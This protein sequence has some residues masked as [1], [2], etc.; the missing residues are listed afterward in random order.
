MIDALARPTSRSGFYFFSTNPLWGMAQ[1]GARMSLAEKPMMCQ[2]SINAC[3]LL[4]V[5]P[6]CFIKTA[7]CLLLL[8]SPV[9]TCYNTFFIC[10]LFWTF[11][12]NGFPLTPFQAIY[13]FFASARISSTF[14]YIIF[15]FI[16]YFHIHGS[17][18]KPHTMNIYIYRGE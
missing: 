13:V 10:P 12:L 16:W 18:G 3:S 15:F 2:L 7:K 11:F 8:S 1:E 5:S 9:Y 17:H 14:E 4:C 6:I